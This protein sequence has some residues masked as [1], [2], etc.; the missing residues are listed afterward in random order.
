MVALIP[1]LSLSRFILSLVRGDPLTLDYQIQMAGSELEAE[2]VK[3]A[4]N[5]YASPSS[6][7]GIRGQERA[8]AI[9]CSHSILASC[10]AADG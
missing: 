10:S 4:T 1:F 6:S 8:P 9:L 2:Q 7:Q 3:Q 5:R